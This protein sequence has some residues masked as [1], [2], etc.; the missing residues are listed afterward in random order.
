[1]YLLKKSALVF[2][3]ILRSFHVLKESGIWEFA[4]R[5]KIVRNTKLPIFLHISSLG[6]YNPKKQGKC[7][8]YAKCVLP[9]P[10]LSVLPFNYFSII[11]PSLSSFKNVKNLMSLGGHRQSPQVQGLSLTFFFGYFFHVLQKYP[12]LLPCEQSPIFNKITKS[13][14]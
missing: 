13:I 9:H 11:Y 6:L 14:L 7:I 2:I 3:V 8:N 5:E 1:V 10:F 4:V 12:F